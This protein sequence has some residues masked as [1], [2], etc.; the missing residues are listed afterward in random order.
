MTCANQRLSAAATGG[1]GM[2]GVIWN[3]LGVPNAV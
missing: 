1:I 3:T 2:S